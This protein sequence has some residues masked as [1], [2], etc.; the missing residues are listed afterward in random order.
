[1]R[2]FRQTLVLTEKAF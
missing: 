1:M 2:L